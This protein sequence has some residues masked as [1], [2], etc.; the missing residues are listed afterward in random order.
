[1]TSTTTILSLHLIDLFSTLTTCYAGSFKG[2]RN[3]YITPD[4]FFHDFFYQVMAKT[5]PVRIKIYFS[6]PLVLWHCWLGSRK[7]IRPVN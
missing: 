5:S 6:L 7:G 1:M 2:S 3:S 4:A